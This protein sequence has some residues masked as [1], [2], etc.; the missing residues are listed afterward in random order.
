VLDRIAPRLHLPRAASARRS[1]DG[2]DGLEPGPQKLLNHHEHRGASTPDG[3][4]HLLS[5]AGWDADAV[6]DELRD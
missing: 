1:V 6:R 5:Q 4:Q 2:G 3:L